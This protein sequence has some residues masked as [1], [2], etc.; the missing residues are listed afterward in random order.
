M[1]V[2]FL[3]VGEACDESIP[4]TS[5]WIQAEGEDG[6]K[7]ILLDCG[8]TVPP[9]YWRQIQDPEDL[10]GLYISHFHGDH[11]FGVPAL[12]LRCWEQKRQKRL[13]VLGQR[14]VE[15]IV[16]RVMDLAYPGFLEKLTYPLEFVSVEPD[17]E[18]RAL[19]LRWTAAQS[20]HSQRNL[21]LRV[22]NGTHSVFYSGDG[23]STPA[24]LELARD[25]HLVVHEAFH[26]D[27]ELPGHGTVLQCLEFARRAKA[28]RLALVHLQRD[29]R[30]LRLQDVR[31]AAG[32]VSDFQVLVPDPGETLEL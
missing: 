28:S 15:E 3:G 31:E 9:C 7:S 6:R 18:T 23:Q 27:K 8:F 22:S 5:I 30:R 4:N 13:I 11:F 2:V 17:S 1:R 14:G 12:L 21:A 16:G 19:G 25:C 32:E 26:L 10:D 20:S 24:T 29:E